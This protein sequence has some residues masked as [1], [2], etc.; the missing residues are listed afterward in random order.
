MMPEV[1]ICG[2]VIIFFVTCI[3]PSVWYVAPYIFSQRLRREREKVNRMYP[4]FIEPHRYCVYPS[5]YTRNIFRMIK[6]TPDIPLFEPIKLKHY[7]PNEI[8]WR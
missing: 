2:V 3:W 6:R 1:M 8:E 5:V 4:S 7:D